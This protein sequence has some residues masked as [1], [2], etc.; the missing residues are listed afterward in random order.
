M[1]LK[2]YSKSANREHMNFTEY[3]KHIQSLNDEQKHIVMFNRQW[4]K[5]YVHAVQKKIKQL[6][7]IKYF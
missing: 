3:C 1:L 6:M 2:L 4:C 7:N 5:N